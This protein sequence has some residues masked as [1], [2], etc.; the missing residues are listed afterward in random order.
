MAATFPSGYAGEMIT[1]AKMRARADVRALDPEMRR[2]MF[3]LMRHAWRSGIPLGIG[4]GGRTSEQQR[5]EFLRRH[6]P[7][8]TGT[9]TYDGRRWARHSWAAPLAPPGLSY[10]EQTPP[11]GA[12]AVDTVPSTSWVWQNNNCH[13][14]GLKHFGNVNGEPWHLNIYEVPN[15]RRDYNTNPNAY[16]L[17]RYRKP[18]SK[19]PGP[20][21]P[22]F[23]KRAQR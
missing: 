10:H 6:Y 18:N 13:L 20:K 23:P 3:R 15:S 22:P 16:P 21:F 12:L 14:F 11:Y 8:P 17:L 7:S 19:K 1:I 2:R 4:G 5:I 9:I